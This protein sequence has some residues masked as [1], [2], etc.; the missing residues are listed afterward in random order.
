MANK[1]PINH[2]VRIII[3]IISSQPAKRSA[4]RKPNLIQA[5][6]TKPTQQ[7]KARRNRKQSKP[8]SVLFPASVS[9]YQKE[10]TLGTTSDRK[11]A[12][13]VSWSLRKRSLF[14]GVALACWRW[15]WIKIARI[16][17]GMWTLPFRSSVVVFLVYLQ[18]S[19][20]RALLATGVGTCGTCMIIIMELL[21]SSVARTL[22]RC[23]RM[24]AWRVWT[25]F[26]FVFSWLRRYC[27]VNCGSGWQMGVYGDLLEQKLYL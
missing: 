9:A 7:W 11:R 2:H 23:L 20:S 25:P 15:R 19:C 17:C 22:G 12:G 21:G 3:A 4:E 1:N 13:G 24:R 5:I 8:C 18:G 27:W 10:P 6:S 14:G 16:G 26:F